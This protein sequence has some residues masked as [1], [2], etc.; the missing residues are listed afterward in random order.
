MRE[1]LPLGFLSQIG[2]YTGTNEKAKDM[3]KQLAKRLRDLA[4]AVENK[5]EMVQRATDLM[6]FDFMISRMPPNEDQI[7]QQG[8][9]NVCF[10]LHNVCR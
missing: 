4:D 6:S 3:A 7:P 2:Q 10:P 8:S 5:P 9:Q 1:E